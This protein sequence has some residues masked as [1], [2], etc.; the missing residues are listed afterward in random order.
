MKIQFLIFLSLAALA[1][2]KSQCVQSESHESEQSENLHVGNQKPL[3]IEELNLD[4]IIQT[5]LNATHL[6]NLQD[7]STKNYYKLVCIKSGTSQLVAGVIYR[8]NVTLQKT[9]CLKSDLF[10]ENLESGDD[11]GL[12]S[13]RSLDNIENCKLST[14][15]Q[16]IVLKV[17]S[18]PWKKVFYQLV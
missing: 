7:N 13:M 15:T 17:L 1:Y 6:Y 18:T 12:L 3:S 16:D 9:E 5:A 10:G 2:G 4:T 8:L 11:S 14:E